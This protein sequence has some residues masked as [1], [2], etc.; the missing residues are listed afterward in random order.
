MI[1]ILLSDYYIINKI[2]KIYSFFSGYCYGCFQYKDESKDYTAH[3]IFKPKN[4]YGHPDSF[5]LSWYIQGSLTS[6]YVFFHCR[7]SSCHIQLKR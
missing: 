3:C 1:Y 4:W 7:K 5:S 2:H 6:K